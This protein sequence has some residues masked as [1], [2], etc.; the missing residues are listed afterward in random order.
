MTTQELEQR[1]L[2][3]EI[4]FSATRSSGAGGQNVNKVNTRVELRFNVVHSSVFDN[5]E[6]EM[7]LANLANRINLN[8]ELLMWSQTERTQLGNKEKVTQRFLEMIAKA[9]TPVK[10]RK[11]TAPSAAAKRKRLDS[12]KRLSEKKERRR[13]AGI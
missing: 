10:K 12:K 3:Y 5:S 8:G 9:L 7:L 2:I 4:D 6:K 1:G 13:D 11:P